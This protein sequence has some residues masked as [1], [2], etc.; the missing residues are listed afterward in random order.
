ML[1]PRLE[2]DEVTWLVDEAVIIDDLSLDDE[3]LLVA[4]VLMRLAGAARSHP[5]ER[6]ACP[7]RERI[8]ELNELL[9]GDLAPV[10]IDIGHEGR[11]LVVVD[12]TVNLLNRLHKMLLR[13]GFVRA[14]IIK[15]AGHLREAP[16]GNA[17]ISPV[18]RA[19]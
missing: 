4:G 16:P 14:I 15:Q 11:C 10:G 3:E 17:S 8:V 6:E 7:L 1:G 12:D 2:K 5:V 13:A 19:V 9:A 18:R